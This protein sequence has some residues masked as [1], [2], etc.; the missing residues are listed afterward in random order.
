MTARAVPL[1]RLG[2]GFEL[3]CKL[4]ALAGGAV[5]AALTVM[6][7]VSIGGRVIGHPIQGDFELVQIG[8]AVGTAFFLPYCQL[9][10]CNIIVDFFTVRSGRRVRGA[11][12]ALGALSV[13]L[14][15]GLLAWRTGVGTI[16]M[17]SSGE[18]SMIIGVPLWYAYA[19]MTISF[20]L[21]GLVG[22]Y[23]S[24]KSWREGRAQL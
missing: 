15:M 21:T 12:D 14:M 11:L 7:T 5:L 24:W 4:L 17:M 23:T 10:R 22:L 16:A 2:R 6:S 3:V 20:G 13:A 9:K 8:C 19:L 18:S 1:D